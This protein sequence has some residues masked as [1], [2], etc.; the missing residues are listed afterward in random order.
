MDENRSGCKGEVKVENCT[1]FAATELA[2]KELLKYV[3]LDTTEI[4]TIG[5]T[6]LTPHET[7]I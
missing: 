3:N 6:C 7:M 4:C 1:L 5:R 2:N